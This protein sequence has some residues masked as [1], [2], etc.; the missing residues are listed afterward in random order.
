MGC[1]SP[2]ADG[3]I[4]PTSVS[5]SIWSFVY[6]WS[7]GTCCS[8]VLIPP[9]L[10]TKWLQ[11]G[12]CGIFGP[13]RWSSPSQ[14]VLTNHIRKW[15]GENETIHAV[16]SDSVHPTHVGPCRCGLY[17]HWQSPG[18]YLELV[19]QPAAVQVPCHYIRRCTLFG[20]FCVRHA[21]VCHERPCRLTYQFALICSSHCVFVTVHAICTESP[22]QK[23]AVVCLPFY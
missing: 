6:I 18:D 19:W 22:A 15:W 1:A 10:L 17:V 9:L 8:L 23:H 21:I 11:Q 2:T 5:P 12:W 3:R 13:I 7:I 14:I 4:H 16:S 20:A